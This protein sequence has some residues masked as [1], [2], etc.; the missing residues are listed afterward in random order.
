M[1]SN[2]TVGHTMRFETS[3]ES[4]QQL[5]I[6]AYERWGQ[7]TPSLTVSPGKCDVAVKKQMTNGKLSTLLPNTTRCNFESHRWFAFRTL[8]DVSICL[9]KSTNSKLG[10]ARL[11]ELNKLNI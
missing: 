3:N 11:C 8:M 2:V 1:T 6:L 5:H 9:S 4:V 7:G 10:R